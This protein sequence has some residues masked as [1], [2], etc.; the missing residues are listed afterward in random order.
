MDRSLDDIVSDR[1][2]VSL[3]AKSI[4]KHQRTDIFQRGPRRGGQYND[5]ARDP[6]RKVGFT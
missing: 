2:Q 3:C 6:P 1:H 4:L 5:R